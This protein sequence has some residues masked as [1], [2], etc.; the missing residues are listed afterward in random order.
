MLMDGT[1]QPNDEGVTWQFKPGD[2]VAPGAAQP[3][4]TPQAP[5]PPASAAP[6]AQAQPTNALDDAITWTASEFVAHQKSGGWYGLL[7]LGAVVVA[8]L[9]W[10]VTKDIV[11]SVVI[12]LA[13]LALGVYG[14]RQPRELDYRLDETGLTIGGKYYNYGGF[15]SFSVMTE[16]AFSSIVFMPLK[17]FSTLTTI[18]YDPKDEDDIVGLLSGRLPLEERKR[19]AIDSLMWRIRF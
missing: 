18:Y 14:R 6:V 15:R 1:K 7:A 5:T 16:G 12:V 8:V 19:D 3:T 9:V 4:P 10:V 2:T 17:R 13:A 11:S